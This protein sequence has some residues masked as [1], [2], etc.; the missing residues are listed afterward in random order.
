[1]SRFEVGMQFTR[2]VQYG[3]SFDGS[4]QVGDLVGLKVEESDLNVAASVVFNITFG[5]LLEPDPEVHVSILAAACNG[6]TFT[7]QVPS[8]YDFQ[9]EYIENSVTQTVNLT[10]PATT[11]SVRASLHLQTVLS[12][13]ATVD[14]K[15][16]CLLAIK[17]RSSITNV[18]VRGARWCRD[19]ASNKLRPG[20]YYVCPKG[21]VPV[22]IP[23]IYRLEDAKSSKDAYR[24]AVGDMSVKANVTVIGDAQVNCTILQ[25]IE[26]T[27]DL[28]TDLRIS[29]SL[30]LGIGKLIPLTDWLVALLAITSPTDE[31]Y[32]QF[33]LKA[34]A[35]LNGTFG[36]IAR[37]RPPLDIAGPASANGNVTHTLD[38]LNID[39]SGRPNVTMEVK[40]PSFGDIRNLTLGELVEILVIAMQLL[41]GESFN[42]TCA[43]GL[44]GVEINDVALFTYPIPGKS[45]FS[46]CVR[47]VQHHQA[48][49]C[50]LNSR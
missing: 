35:N 37:A 22:V 30:T 14:E 21:D 45:S 33:F 20:L 47:I 15:T 29:L 25:E 2:N 4:L 38:F 28:V 34:R 1:M 18:E 41:V 27:A 12:N 10:I 8:F 5:I 49:I 24:V 44:L 36:A 11:S 26:V 46:V 40:M 19:L 43:E 50:T 6:T 32:I 39:A 48:L 9:L 13:L 3:T 7:C 42:S 23:N 17:F 31:G 16:E